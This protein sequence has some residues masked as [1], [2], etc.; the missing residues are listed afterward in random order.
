MRDVAVGG[1]IKLTFEREP[2]PFAVFRNVPG[3]Q[4]YLVARDIASGDVVGF[5]ERFVHLAYVDGEPRRLSWIGNLRVRP[6]YRNRISLLKGGLRAVHD[7]LTIPSD[8]D[9][10]AA[11]ITSDNAIAIRLLE[12]NLPGMPTFHRIGTIRTLA[13]RS[14][15]RFVSPDVEQAS[16]RDIPAIAELLRACHSKRQL[17]PVVDEQNLHRFARGKGPSPAD[18]FVIRQGDR[19]RGCICLWDQSAFRQTVVRGYS[20]W[21]GV[22]RPIVNL[23]AAAFGVPSLPAPN[24]HIG[25][26]YL[27]LLAVDGDDMQMALSLID[28]ALSQAHRRGAKAGLLGV[29]SPSPLQAKIEANYRALSYNSNV[30]LVDMSL[31]DTPQSTHSWEE[32]HPEIA[33]L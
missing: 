5:G 20:G 8:S 10:T 18:F 6:E 33:L 25:H 2:D 19:L 27:S 29:M 32:T 21:L 22:T 30:Y 15:Q 9:F 17:A 7:L 16:E 28:A 3:E 26:A 11:T 1:W 13:L 23:A 12:A 14:R 24:Q 4:I 31:S